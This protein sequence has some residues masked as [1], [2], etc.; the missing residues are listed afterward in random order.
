MTA[1]TNLVVTVTFDGTNITP[2]PET[3]EMAYGQ[4]DSITWK[5]KN[6]ASSGYSN[7]RFSDIYFRDTPAWPGDAPAVT[8]SVAS[9]ADNN[10]TT[11]T[12]QYE[13][14]INIAWE[15][16]NPATTSYKCIDPPVEN[17]PKDD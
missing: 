11:A 8:D 5:L 17:D 9:V 1:Q 3:A 13:Y 16:G 14:G 12:V 4:N 2:D 15:S 10:Q 7:V 6:T